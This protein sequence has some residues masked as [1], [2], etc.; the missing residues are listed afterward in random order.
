M[1]EE[2]TNRWP[3]LFD[4]F[5]DIIMEVDKKCDI[6]E[7]TQFL[8]ERKE[9]NAET[10]T[11]LEKADDWI[12]FGV[13]LKVLSRESENSPVPVFTFRPSQNHCENLKKNSDKIDKAIAELNCKRAEKLLGHARTGK[14]RKYTD[15]HR[16]VESAITLV[17]EQ[18]EK[19][20]NGQFKWLHIHVKTEKQACNFI[21][22][23]YLLR[24]KLALPKGSSIPEKKLEALDNAWEWAKRGSPE[25]DD[26]KMEVALQKHRW[27]PNLG[28]RW[29]QKQ[30]NA[31]LDSNKL[32][33]SNPLHWAVN[34]IVGDKALVSE[35]YDLEMLNDASVRNLT[36]NWEW[37]DKS[38]IPLYQARAAFRTHASDLDRRLINAVKK[39]KWLPLSHHLWEDT[40]ALIKNVSED[41]SFNGKWEMAAILAWAICQNAEARIKLSVQLR[42]YW[43]R[44][45]E[46]YDLAFQAALKRKRPFLLVRIT[47]S[48]KSRPTIKMQAAEKSFAN[49]AAFQ[50]YLEAETLFATGNFNA[51]LK[52]LNSV[53][54]EKMRTRN[55]RA[56][57]EGWA[58]V[59]FNIIDKNESHALVV[60]NGKCHP[61]RIDLSE[62]WDAFQKW[63]TERRDLKLIKKSETSLEILCEKSGIMLEP[64]LNQIKSENILFIPYGFLHLVPLHA[65]K[66][67]KPDE[68][69]TYLFQEK[70][71]LF[72]PSWSLAPVEK[73]NIHTGEHDLLLLAKMRGKDIQNIMDREDWC[74]EKNA[75]NIENTADDFFNC[76]FD[77]LERFRK[78]PHL[79]VLYCHGQGD[80]VNP[81]CSKFIM[82]GRPLTHQDIV[83]DLQD[84]PV[85]QGTKV[86]LTAC[87]TDLVSRHFGLIDEHLSLA[88]A[89]LCKGASQ[90]IASLFTCTTDI[91]CEIIVHAKDNPEKS[92][93]QILQEKQNQWAANEALYRLSVFRVMGFPGSARAME[94][95]I[96]P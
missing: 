8:R 6:E 45:R 37:K 51:G 13:I 93:G 38:G 12:R 83:Q 22:K 73:E 28:K 33:L 63:N 74:N 4:K 54:I 18:F 9:F 47:D 81:Y 88:T 77:T 43:S 84:L 68:T 11:S 69:Y 14:V 3:D 58:A 46:L 48:E 41:D 52:E 27:D 82:E 29:F 92:L 60:E 5:E 44:A 7:R 65:S 53:P 23:C 75:E 94:E 64:I 30:L 70:Q 20:D 55:I 89:F 25:T 95:E 24:S 56:V 62:V 17:W 90:V 78:P 40:V 49:A 15:R 85:L 61:I 2:Q 76:L 67:K 39:L 26:L 1:N 42:W 57:P 31:F 32:D 71:C 86:I 36:K 96:S 59:H 16:L 66:I 91:S 19:R 34:D 87:E 10:L 80:F 72:L 21:A 35:E 79:L 50:T